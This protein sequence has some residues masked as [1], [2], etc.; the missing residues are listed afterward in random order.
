MYFE[1]TDELS[2]NAASKD[3]SKMS[4]LLEKGCKK[5]HLR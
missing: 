5:N 2:I 1:T 4:S 3:I